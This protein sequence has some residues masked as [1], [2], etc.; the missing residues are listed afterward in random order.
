MFEFSMV[1]IQSTEACREMEAA[2]FTFQSAKTEDAKLVDL[3]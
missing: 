2:T 1:P 3:A